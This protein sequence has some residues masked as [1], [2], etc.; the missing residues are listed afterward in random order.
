MVVEWIQALRWQ[1]KSDEAI[2]IEINEKS[3][4][5]NFNKQQIGEVFINAQT[6]LKKEI[7]K[8]DKQ[9]ME[10]SQKSQTSDMTN[11]LMQMLQ[12]QQ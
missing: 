6:V 2:K 3:K 7:T 9:R 11:V 8:S 12:N 5:S 1:R 4:E 10:F